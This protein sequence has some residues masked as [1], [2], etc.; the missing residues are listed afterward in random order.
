MVD[1]IKSFFGDKSIG[2][3]CSLTAALCLLLGV[4][5]FAALTGVS[6]EATESPATVI[7]FA[8]V[9]LLLCLLTAV[10]DIF[11]LP[12][13]VAMTFAFMTFG[14]F[15]KGRISYLAFYFSGDVM[16][17]G[18]SPLFILSFIFILL[19]AIASCMAV[20]LNQ[21]KNKS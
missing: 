8:V 6:E 20:F 10:K 12:S 1:K 4:I 19:A 14:A 17:T 15:I 18:L 5:F 9:G 7:A 21:E 2:F 16:N 3:Y 13:L 11:K